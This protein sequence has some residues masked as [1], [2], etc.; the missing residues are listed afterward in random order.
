[1]VGP[2]ELQRI[3]KSEIAVLRA[4]TRADVLGVLVLMTLPTSIASAQTP[5]LVPQAHVRLK[6]QGQRRIWVG[7]SVEQRFDSLRFVADASADTLL[8]PIHNIERLDQS[9]GRIDRRPRSG[10][11]IGGGIGALLGVPIGYSVPPKRDPYCNPGSGNVEAC[12][13]RKWNAAIGFGIGAFYGSLVGALVGLSIRTERWT[14]I[15]IKGK[16]LAITTFLDGRNA[17]GVRAQM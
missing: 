7:R 6:M 9:L 11:I 4:L 15:I 8:V 3:V 1:M 14:P 5:V 12:H 17:I 16:P 2:T 10:A 13:T